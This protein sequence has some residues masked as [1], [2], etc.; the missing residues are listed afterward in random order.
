MEYNGQFPHQTIEF[1]SSTV[2]VINGDC[3]E[4][5]K[6][7]NELGFKFNTTITSP[8]Y[9]EQRKDVYDSISPADFPSWYTGISTDIMNV[10]HDDGSYFFNIKEHV[11]K[12]KRDVYVYKTIIDMSNV[13]NWSDEYI[14]NKTNPFPTGAKTR[15]KDGFERIYQFNHTTK[16]KFFPD[17]VK[18]QSTSKYLESEKK[19]KN[20]GEH[21]VNNGSSMN[22]TKR[23]AE[24]MVRPSNV[25]TCSTSNLNIGHPAVFPID[26]PNFYI[27][28]TTE[29]NDWVLDPFGGS[30]TTALSSIQLGRNCVLIEKSEQYYNLI[31]ERLL[32]YGRENYQ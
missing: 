23:V 18:V 29:P 8:P 1:N 3:T 6:E 28:L 11:D 22:M 17:E 19:R 4:V 2:I 31:I 13:Y 7:L 12:G 9:A 14:W 16:Y 21:N 32:Q 30:G 10:L 20:K 25:L 26:I 15:L 24:D 27:K 5:L